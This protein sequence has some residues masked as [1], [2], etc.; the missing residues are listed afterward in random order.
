MYNYL[1]PWHELIEHGLI[2]FAVS[3]EEQTYE[4]TTVFRLGNVLYGI[5][6]QYVLALQTLGDY[7][8]LPFVKPFYVGFV[9]TPLGM[10]PVIDIR[11]QDAATHYR[12]RPDMDLLIVRLD[13]MNVGLLADALMSPLPCG[14]ITPDYQTMMRGKTVSTQKM[15]I[16]E[17]NH[18]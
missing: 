17:R 7:I 18:Q 16:H 13:T 10:L 1:A 9:P 5:P 12:I 4:T 3:Q 15:F 14:C 2:I 11:P 6:S 8:P